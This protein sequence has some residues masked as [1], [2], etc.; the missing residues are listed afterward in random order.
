MLNLLS[1]PCSMPQWK[2][3]KMASDT[4]WRQLLITRYR[5]LQPGLQWQSQ[6]WAF[7][8]HGVAK[9]GEGW[10]LQVLGGIGQPALK[11]IILLAAVRQWGVAHMSD[12]IVRPDQFPL[13]FAHSLD[14][15]HSEILP[16][17]PSFWVCRQAMASTGTW[18]LQQHSRLQ[19]VF[20]HLYLCGYTP[21]PTP[22]PSNEHTP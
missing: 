18:S 1:S 19:L 5:N 14:L 22:T 12:V 2:S 7:F 8:S 10:K 3:G 17:T 13:L 4:L 20:P 21:S 6:M 15:P 16:G 11:K 9:C